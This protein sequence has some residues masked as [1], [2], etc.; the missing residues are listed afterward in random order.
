LINVARGSVINEDALAEALTRGV[1][2]CAG[3]DVYADKPQVPARLLAMEQVV[4]LPHLASATHETRQA[5]A[6]LVVDNLDAFYAPGQLK[7]GVA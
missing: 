1:I 6:E 2:A 5:I 3:L 4:L 7:A